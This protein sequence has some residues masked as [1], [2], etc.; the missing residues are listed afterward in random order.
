MS[1]LTGSLITLFQL[2]G[3]Q[4][5]HSHWRED[6]Y[7]GGEERNLQAEQEGRERE[8]WVLRRLGEPP[9]S[10]KVNSETCHLSHEVP[11]HKVNNQDQRFFFWLYKT[12]KVQNKLYVASS[13]YRRKKIKKYSKYQNSTF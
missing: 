7:Q 6:F 5:G 9:A 11:V 10:K 12:I 4:A 8:H 3:R 2:P 13:W 1:L